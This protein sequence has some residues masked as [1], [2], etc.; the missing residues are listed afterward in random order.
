MPATVR[1]MGHS[2]AHMREAGFSPD[3]ATYNALIEGWCRLD[4][5]A[6]AEAVVPAMV[7]AGVLPTGSTY[8]I[9]ANANIRLGDTERAEKIM[10]ARCMCWITRTATFIG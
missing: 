4:D 5:L 10:T 1:L 8:G 6:A 7:K 3:L 2:L 9:L